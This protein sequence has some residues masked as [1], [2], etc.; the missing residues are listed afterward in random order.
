LNCFL[1]HKPVEHSEE[2]AFLGRYAHQKCFLDSLLK[3]RDAVI[4][5][6][7]LEKERINPSEKN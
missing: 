4:A 7:K 5:V 1:C 2:S 3:Q 6:Q